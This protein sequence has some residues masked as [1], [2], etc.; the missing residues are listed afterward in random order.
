MNFPKHLYSL[1]FSRGFAAMAVI[2]VH[3]QHFLLNK[4]SSKTDFP[5][6][7]TLKLFYNDGGF[8][9]QYF[10]QLSGFIFF[11]LYYDKVKNNLIDFKSF[12]IAR[13]SRLYPLH[14]FNSNIVC[15]TSV[16]LYKSK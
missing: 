9:V 13:F 12:S 3:W 8:A 5:L 1:D 4:V 10:F 6:Y 11:W 7:S 15:I 16:C 14:F 2:L